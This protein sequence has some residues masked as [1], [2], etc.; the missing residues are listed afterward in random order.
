M[1][2]FEYQKNNNSVLRISA[3]AA[4]VCSSLNRSWCAVKLERAQQAQPESSGAG[5]GTTQLEPCLLGDPYG[6]PVAGFAEIPECASGE[7]GSP[8][9]CLQSMTRK[10]SSAVGFM[11]PS[12]PDLQVERTH[13]RE[14]EVTRE[15]TRAMRDLIAL[16]DEQDAVASVSEKAEVVKGAPDCK[17][18]HSQSVRA[19]GA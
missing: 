1:S 14:S 18:H 5:A 3:C 17:R 7:L 6:W 12:I 15:N 19:K 2:S 4:Q 8:N 10:A 9:R 13:E 11:G 16:A